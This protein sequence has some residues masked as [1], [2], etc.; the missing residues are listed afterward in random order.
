MGRANNSIFKMKK[1]QKREENQ[2][3]KKKSRQQFCSL[4]KAHFI[5]TE[6]ECAKKKKRRRP[7]LP[8][9]YQTD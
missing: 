2:N 8:S 1:E 6:V 9:M 5:N 3:R 7:P 4:Q